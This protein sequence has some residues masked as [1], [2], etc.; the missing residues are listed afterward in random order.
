MVVTHP[1][2]GVIMGNLTPSNLPCLPVYPIGRGV[3]YDYDAVGGFSR[4]GAACVGRG[5][6]LLQP[7]L[8]RLAE[9]VVEGDGGGPDARPHVDLP[10]AEAVELV[11]TA[12]LSGGE[13]EISI[14][15]E[16]EIVVLLGKG[17]IESE[18]LDLPKH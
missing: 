2:S 8:D 1:P 3:V 10:W 9:S 5:Q 18:R 11:K 17:R 4:V 16:L 15:D 7:L 6:A 14:G 12:F 13:R